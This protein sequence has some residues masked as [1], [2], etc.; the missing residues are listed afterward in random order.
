L[1]AHK[2]PAAS[3]DQ[4]FFDARRK[5]RFQLEVEITI[6]SRTCG[7]LTGRTLDISESGVSALL[8][9]EVPLGELVELEFTL[10][11]G[12]VKIFATVRQKSAFRYGFEFLGLTSE[13][14]IILSTCSHLAV[15]QSRRPPSL[16]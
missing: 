6:H 15:E 8:A 9:I 7:L 11:P 14:E 10:P 16:T 5:P 2:Q 3:V 1:E 4:D 13:K 12:L